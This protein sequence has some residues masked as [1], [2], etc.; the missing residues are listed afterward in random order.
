MV[1]PAAED[2]ENMTPMMK[3]YFQ[4]KNQCLDAILFFRMGDFF[5]VFGDDAQDI[6]PQL[7]IVLTSRERGDKQRIHF[8]GVPHHS[9]RSYWLRL[10][11][12]GYKIAIADQ[13]EDASLAKSF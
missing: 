10:L 11:R 12:K 3:Q 9:A 7:N 5:E 6:S 8:C 13:M 1:L 4:L 2:I